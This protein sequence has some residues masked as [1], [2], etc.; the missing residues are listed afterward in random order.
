MPFDFISKYFSFLISHPLLVF[1]F[2]L[3]IS[4]LS[5]LSFVLVYLTGL[6]KSAQVKKIG[7][8]GEL[9]FKNTLLFFSFNFV[10]PWENGKMFHRG[11]KNGSIIFTQLLAQFTSSPIIIFTNFHSLL[12]PVTNLAGILPFPFYLPIFYLLQFSIILL[13]HEL[14][15]TLPFFNLLL[16]SPLQSLTLLSSFASFHLMNRKSLDNFLHHMIV[17]SLI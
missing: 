13:V 6:I 12:V 2:A 5:K 4:I 15:P 16:F 17:H 7:A 14:Q 10:K 9:S 8:N 1:K 11:C 3:S